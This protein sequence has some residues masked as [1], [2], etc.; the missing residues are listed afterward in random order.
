MINILINKFK[1][2]KLKFEI[3]N[4]KKANRKLE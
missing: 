4:L 3:D 2:I 1:N